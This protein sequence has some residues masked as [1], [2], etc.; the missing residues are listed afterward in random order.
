MSKHDYD[1]LKSTLIQYAKNKDI[2]GVK[3]YMSKHIDLI[4]DV[5][6]DYGS[7]NDYLRE[8]YDITCFSQ[9]RFASNYQEYLETNVA[10][11][12]LFSNE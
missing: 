7:G 10:G 1:K 6:C 2:T 8:A 4:I 11:D 5:Y 3:D 9:P 12:V